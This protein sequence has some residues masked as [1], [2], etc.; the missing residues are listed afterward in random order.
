LNNKTVFIS[1]NSFQDAALKCKLAGY[2]AI[3]SG[4]NKLGQFVVFGR[5]NGFGW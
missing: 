3:G 4:R 5:K 2:T 1:N